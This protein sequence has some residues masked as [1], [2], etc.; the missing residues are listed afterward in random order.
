MESKQATQPLHG[1]HQPVS[2]K[3]VNVLAALQRLCRAGYTAQLIER[4]RN[5]HAPAG[6][7]R[8]GASDKVIIV[9][10]DAVTGVIEADARKDGARYDGGLMSYNWASE[11]IAVAVLHWPTANMAPLGINID[12]VT[13][14]DGS[15]A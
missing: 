11:E 4:S 9:A 13:A 1:T 8:K 6:H 2:A 5:R 7:P 3:Y 15:I 12:R 10:I 14:G